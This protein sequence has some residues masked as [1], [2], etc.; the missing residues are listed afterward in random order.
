VAPW[1]YSQYSLVD[2]S[3]FA[4]A[5][6][7][8]PRPQSIL[9]W[10]FVEGLRRAPADGARPARTPHT[11]RPCAPPPLRNAP[12]RARRAT[13][14]TRPAAHHPPN[15]VA[16][17]MGALAGNSIQ[18]I[19]YFSVSLAASKRR[20]SSTKAEGS[21]QRRP[22][23]PPT[24]PI[25]SLPR[26]PYRTP[27]H[28]VM[29]PCAPTSSTLSPEWATGR[30]SSTT[31]TT[32]TSSTSSTTFSS[33]ASSSSGAVAPGAPSCG[34]GSPLPAQEPAER[35]EAA[36]ADK[37]MAMGMAVG[38]EEEEEEARHHTHA[39]EEPDPRREL[40]DLLNKIFEMDGQQHEARRARLDK[41]A[42][43]RKAAGKLEATRDVSWADMHQ[44]EA[45]LAFLF[46][47]NL[48]DFHG[49][50]MA[51]A[52]GRHEERRR[53][54]A[55]ILAPF[56]T[57]RSD[58]RSLAAG[59]SSATPAERSEVR[60][61]LCKALGRP[62][63]QLSDD[64]RA[65]EEIL[66]ARAESAVLAA[67][68]PSQ[69]L[70]TTSSAAVAT[71][72]AAGN[73]ASVAL[74][75]GEGLPSSTPS[76]SSASPSSSGTHATGAGSAAPVRR[77]D[78]ERS[79]ETIP[80]AGS[81]GNTSSGFVGKLR[82]THRRARSIGDFATSTIMKRRKDEAEGEEEAGISPNS[83]SS[84]LPTAATEEP[85]LSEVKN[86]EKFFILYGMDGVVALKNLLNEVRKEREEP[87]IAGS[88]RSPSPSNP[89]SELMPISDDL[90]TV[91]QQ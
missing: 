82:H 89:R 87:S 37:E 73:S 30:L 26:I 43:L 84:A 1:R 7:L 68:K 41:D 71:L 46:G 81:A 58:P 3:S 77:K 10:E 13:S 2:C 72:A 44:A 47:E 57:L 31:S 12:P 23:I 17:I 20:A 32:S 16:S 48:E 90:L 74:A 56:A 42:L 36:K 63:E 78:R 8:L 62:F 51:A 14:S 70:A 35:A 53:K 50:S 66:A 65:A 34:G 45:W 9:G 29:E 5:T 21:P 67:F 54:M 27:R 4:A 19:L 24:P 6:H 55:S 25:P 88:L 76:S 64:L 11:T 85:N 28:L 22:P 38:M 60:L 59:S 83:S 40:V 49:E 18:A 75:S 80:L 91:L 69:A 86:V 39:Q 79:E 15:A 52:G 33:P 61:R